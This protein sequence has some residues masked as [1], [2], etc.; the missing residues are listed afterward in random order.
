MSA[1]HPHGPSDLPPPETQEVSN[2]IFAY[3]QP[4]GSWGLNNTGFIVGRG[5]VVAVD[6]CF[7]ESR[8]R[9][10]LEAMGKVTDLPVRTLVNT[11]HHG[12]H[13]NGNYLLPSAT[14]VGHELC[15]QRGHTV[16]PRKAPTPITTRTI[17]QMII[18]PTPT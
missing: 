14:I 18:R 1:G 12:D 4:D 17:P 11:H 9:A 15:R 16:I 13:T 5:G 7:T 8:T 10:L 2:G 6:T 3:L